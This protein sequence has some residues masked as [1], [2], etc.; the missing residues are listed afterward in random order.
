MSDSGSL[1]TNESATV[2]GHSY[3]NS[4]IL[5]MNPGPAS[6]EYNL[7]RQWRKLDVTMG[8]RDDS[9]DNQSEQF[10]LVADGRTIYSRVFTLGQSKH[11]VISVS[12]IL[13]LEMETTLVS[14]NYVG[15]VY[16]VWGS[17]SLSS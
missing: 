8:L 6:V 14:S 11:V 15:P 3:T 10:R 13:R 9:A 12:G 7:G 1:Y 5:Y 17:A 16:A 2:N 4:V